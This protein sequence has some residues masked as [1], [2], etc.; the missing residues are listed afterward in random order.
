MT[1]TQTSTQRL[2]LVGGSTGHLR[3]AHATGAQVVWC[4]QPADIRPEH[5][6][7]AAEI[8]PVDYTDWEQLRPAVLRAHEQAPFAAAVSLT[9]PG[10]DP[11]AL[12]NDLLGLGG[13]SYEV[14]HL[15]TDKWLMRERLR[16]AAATDG[17][18]VVAAALLGDRDSLDAF[19]TAHGYPFIVKPTSG[20]ASFGVMKVNSPA[21]LDATWQEVSR[22][23]DS[24]HPLIGDYDI[25]AFIMEEFVEGTLCSAETFSCDGHH[26]V[27]SI[28]EGITDERNHV[29]A[30]HVAP[31]RITPEQEAAVHRMACDFLDAV[32]LRNGPTHT[33]FMMSPRGPVI[34]E[35]QNRVGGGL[36]GKLAEVVYGTDPQL[37]ALTWALR[38]VPSLTERAAGNGAA[39]SWIIEAEPGRIQE[40]RG[41]DEVHAL[42]STAAVDLWVGP[43]D[44]V[45]PFKGQ[46]DGLGH[47]A[48]RAENADEAIRVCRKT[49]GL[50]QIVTEG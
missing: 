20:T 41:L 13:T 1:S 16:E 43:G 19:G 28:T 10:L 24:D 40:I 38:Q 50:L 44:V 49:L 48:V 30:G 17:S 14:S 42:P 22:L 4:Q 15:F 12:V 23:R 7:L 9:E 33:E 11:V 2:L 8:I 26:V 29:Q 27:M 46:W 25:D 47:V 32:G 34:I 37:L 5:A 31:A 39:A 36:I 6:E 35:S 21:E 45:R 3:K 18:I